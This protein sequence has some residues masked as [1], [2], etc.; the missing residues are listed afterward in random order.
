MSL[1]FQVWVRSKRFV[2]EPEFYERHVI[3]EP[4][5]RFREDIVAIVERLNR[6]RKSDEEF[7]MREHQDIT[8]KE[9]QSES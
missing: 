5:S 6:T 3:D 1:V 8:Q 9:L 4:T 7:F 2:H